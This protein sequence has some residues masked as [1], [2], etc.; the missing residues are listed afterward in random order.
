LIEHLKKNNEKESDPDRNLVMSFLPYLKKLNDDQKLE[1]QIHALKYLKNI[2]QPQTTPGHPIYGS[3]PTYYP[4]AQNMTSNMQY[5]SNP[6]VS[7][8]PYSYPYAS[9]SQTSVPP[10]EIP[11]NPLS[12][13]YSNTEHAIQTQQYTPILQPSPSDNL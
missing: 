3:Y 2:T 12:S 10:I 8:H 7:T 4:L 6:S 11:I 9:H 5:P 1:F 13:Q